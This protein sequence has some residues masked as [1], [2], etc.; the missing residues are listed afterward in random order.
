[1]RRKQLVAAALTSIITVGCMASAQAVNLIQAGTMVGIGTGCASMRAVLRENGMAATPP[2]QDQQEIAF[3]SIENTVRNHNLTIRSFQKTLEGIKNTDVDS[4][5]WN[6]E[7]TYHDQNKLLEQQA[8]GYE[9]SA[10]QLREA[11]AAAAPGSATQ[12]ALTAQ[13]A[14]ME[15]LARQ[16]RI[17]M[18]M[19]EGILTGLDDAREDAKDELEETYDA[20]KRQLENAADQI[21][22]GAQTQYIALGTMRENLEEIDRGIAALDRAIPVMEKQYDLGMVSQQAVKELKNQKQAVTSGRK[23]LELQM[24]TLQNTLSLTLG[25]HAGTTVLVQQLPEVT[26]A[27]LSRMN[28]TADLEEARKNSYAIWQKKEAVRKASNDY[29]DHVTSTLHALNAAKIDLQAA[30]QT[31]ENSFRELFHAVSE[32]QRLVEEAQ[33]DFELAQSKFQ[34]AEVKYARGMISKLEYETEKDTLETARMKTK[35]AKIDLFTAYNTYR[36]AIRGVM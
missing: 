25:N 36:W 21:V 9:S 6:Q 13:A 34:A 29:K 18:Q 22:I 10:K 15:L 1:M 16:A 35:T 30:E 4:Q 17:S 3:Q 24:Q 5:F 20:T 12:Q 27:D 33:A 28:D 2:V 19:N 23:T 14:Q 8:K 7:Q 11:A 26:A 32:K 31:M